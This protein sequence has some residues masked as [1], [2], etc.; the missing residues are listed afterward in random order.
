MLSKAQT[1]AL[2]HIDEPIRHDNGFY[3]TVLVGQMAAVLDEYGLD[4]SR[5]VLEQLYVKLV[6]ANK[7]DAAARFAKSYNL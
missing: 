2:G 1:S 6:G 5:E 3:G 4:H 7:H